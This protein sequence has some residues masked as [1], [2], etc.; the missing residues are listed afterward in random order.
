M[1]NINKCIICDGDYAGKKG[2]ACP[3]CHKIVKDHH[4]MMAAGNSELA[5]V[6]LSSSWE[7]VGSGT[8][9][10]QV[11]KLLVSVFNSFPEVNYTTA[12][13]L[14]SV[15]PTI[16]RNSFSRGGPVKFRAVPMAIAQALADLPGAI[17][18]ANRAAEASGL[19]KGRNLLAQLAAGELTNN[20]FER[21]AGIAN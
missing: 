10:D 15:E 18:N 13:R 17:Y 21:R 16:Q 1:R 14:K 9:A 12:S 6:E 2:L 8:E 11:G 20:D 4:A 7:S 5:R 3:Q 19:Q